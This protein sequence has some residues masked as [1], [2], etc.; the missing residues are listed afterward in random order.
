MLVRDDFF[1]GLQGDDQALARAMRLCEAALRKNPRDPAALVWHGN[2]LAFT[3]GR[4]FNSGGAADWYRG[5]QEMDDAVAL[6]PDDLQVRIP[7]ATALSGM[8]RYVSDPVVAE[9][10]LRKSADDFARTEAVQHDVLTTLPVHSR[11]ELWMGIADVAARL[12]ERQRARLYLERAVRELPG[13][14][15]AKKAAAWLKSDAPPALPNGY[16]CLGCHSE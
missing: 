10:L 2:G 14:V 8:S 7:R 13:T 4:T 3:G 9:G 16:T 1:A 15:Y 11:G 6:A 5:L 12:G